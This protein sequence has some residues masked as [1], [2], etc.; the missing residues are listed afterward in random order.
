MAAASP[1]SAAAL[2]ASAALWAALEAARPSSAVFS[3]AFSTSSSLFWS[4]NLASSAA[5]SFSSLA[6]SAPSAAAA[7]PAV[8]APARPALAASSS[9]CFWARAASLSAQV[10]WAAF[11]WSCKLLSFWA[12]FSS[13]SAILTPFFA[14]ISL[15]FAHA[16]ISA[17]T[18]S[19]TCFVVNQF[20]SPASSACS[21]SMSAAALATSSPALASPALSCPVLASKSLSS[22]A[23]CRT[24]WYAASPLDRMSSK[25]SVAVTLDPSRV[26]AVSNR[27]LASAPLHWANAALIPSAATQCWCS[28]V[29]RGMAAAPRDTA[30][31]A[32]ER[33]GSGEHWHAVVTHVSMMILSRVS[34]SLAWAGML[35][36]IALNTS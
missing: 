2:A 34:A 11:S 22:D 19:V 14:M 13:V 24:L 7:A 36:I 31:K 35:G 23:L 28:S 15:L 3:F 18:R 32:E 21:L 4:L 17:S 33:M 26:L 12:I 1:V 5:R 25:P 29:A 16:S 9:P 10:F 20:F 6:F 27:S 30:W 8:L